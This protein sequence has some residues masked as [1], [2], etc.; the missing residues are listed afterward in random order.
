MK[1]EP[2][3]TELRDFCNVGYA[4]QCSKL[5]A[6]RRADAVRFSVASQ[7]GDNE[8]S[9]IDASDNEDLIIVR[10]VCER[11]HAPVDHGE[12]RYQPSSGQFHGGPEDAVLRRQAECYVAAYLERR[13]N[14]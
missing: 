2:S 5:P 3:D 9:D 10:Y 1:S 14:L 4:R 6:D 13:S 11:D 8:A 12:L 7:A